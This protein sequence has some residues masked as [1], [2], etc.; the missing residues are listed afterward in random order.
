VSEEEPPSGDGL[1]SV[2]CPDDPAEAL[3]D[4]ITH[5]VE[6]GALHFGGL[7]PTGFE[8]FCFD[9]MQVCGFQNVDWRKGTPLPSSPADRGRDIVAYQDRLDVDGHRFVEQWFVDCKHYERGVPPEALQGAIAWAMAERP[10]TVLFIASGYL[11]NAAKDWIA[12]FEQK[13]NPPFRVRVW[14]LPQLR[15]LVADHLDIA[16]KHDVGTST[17][18]RVSE[19]LVSE[20]ELTDKLWWGRKPDPRQPLPES[21]AN[22]PPEI[23]EGYRK[24]HA[25]MIEQYGEEELMSHV[26]SQFA[27]GMLSGKVS[28]L[29][30]VLGDEWDVLDS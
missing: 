27:W 30:W 12:D 9:L 28:A 7:S 4:D 23:I 24:A 13:T 25:Q 8:E 1:E 26:Q 18:R 17:L 14:E 29:R 15:R 22:T 5:G 10:S 6:L 2:E 20:S 3:P 11:T 16:F 19:I 21:W